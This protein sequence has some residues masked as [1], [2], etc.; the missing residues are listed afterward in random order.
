MV[1]R[2]QDVSEASSKTDIDN[3]S[4]HK[5]LKGVRSTAGGFMWR[6]DENEVN[7]NISSNELKEA[8]HKQGLTEDEVK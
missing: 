5:V 2:Y 6:Y 4:I 3:G 7:E 8:I 1:G